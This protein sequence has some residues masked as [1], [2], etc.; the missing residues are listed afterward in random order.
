[1]TL[2]LAMQASLYIA[3]TSRMGKWFALVR[4]MTPATFGQIHMMADGAISSMVI[5][6]GI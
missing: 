5:N 3:D 1:M 2:T 4:K 6:H